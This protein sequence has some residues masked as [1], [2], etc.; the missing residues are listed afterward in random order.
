[1]F[2]SIANV[3]KKICGNV[4]DKISGLFS[5]KKMD[6]SF[7]DELRSILISSDAGV[8]F[9]NK[10]VSFLKTEMKKGVDEDSLKASL[11]RELIRLLETNNSVDFDPDVA[12]LV[13]VNGSGKTTFAGKYSAK[14][15]NENK[16]VLMVAADT[17]RAAAVDQL[18]VWSDKVGVDVHKPSAT[19]DS[20][21]VIFDGCKRFRDEKF[22][23]LVIDSSGRVQ[24]KEHLM[25]ELEKNLKVIRK[26]LSDSKIGVWLTIDSMLGQNSL[27]QAKVFSEVVGL[28]GVVLTKADGTGKGGIIFSVKEELGLPVI[29][30]SFGEGIDS[31]KKFDHQDYIRDLFDG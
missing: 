28:D 16:K 31:L 26:N 13:G 10:I 21:S 4:G 8:T 20:S 23:R 3:F 17:F 2:S 9:T 6:E 5:S 24:S 25:R 15:K 18:G 19:Q 12:L 29:Y 22:D 11:E 7:L 14:L 30:T 27:N 1:M